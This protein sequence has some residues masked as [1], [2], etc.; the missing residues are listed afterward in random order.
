MRAG[1]RGNRDWTTKAASET[2]LQRKTIR[3]KSQSNMMLDERPEP[4]RAKLNY[5]LHNSSLVVHG[6]I[7]NV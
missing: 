7:R 1:V 3:V 4:R 5:T 2:T 6:C